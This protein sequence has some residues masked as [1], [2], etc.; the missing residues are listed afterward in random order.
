MIQQTGQVQAISTQDTTGEGG[1][2]LR[3]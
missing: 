2:R 1:A 3:N